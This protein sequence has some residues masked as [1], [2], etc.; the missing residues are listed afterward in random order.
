M[1]FLFCMRGLSTVHPGYHWRSRSGIGQDVFRSIRRL[2]KL[3]I[4]L[5]EMLN[6]CRRVYK[7]TDETPLLL[8][9]RRRLLSRSYLCGTHQCQCRWWGIWQGCECCFVD[10]GNPMSLPRVESASCNLCRMIVFWNRVSVICLCCRWRMDLLLHSYF[11]H[12]VFGYMP[13]STVS[14]SVDGVLQKREI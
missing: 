1:H 7:P 5:P 13:L 14:A 11:Q 3:Q 4:V 12:I 6:Y 2:R 9:W 10:F 8:P